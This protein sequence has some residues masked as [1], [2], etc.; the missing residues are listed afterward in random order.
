MSLSF[1]FFSDAALTTPITT[2]LQFLQ[3]ISSPVAEDKTIY[4]GSAVASRVCEADSNPGVDAVTVSIVDSAGGSGS[5][6]TD[7][8][9]ALSSVGLGSATG[10]ATLAL[11]TT[12][13]S[14]SG[15]AVPIYVRV[16]DSTHAGGLN[17]DLSLQTNTLRETPV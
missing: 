5:P 10:G 8:K 2:P 9:L 3:A 7:V 11:P 17:L 15:N 6:A 1:G 13:N 4:F 12:I 16:L 14:S